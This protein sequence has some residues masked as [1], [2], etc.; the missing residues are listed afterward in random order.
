[1]SK[2]C[3]FC[4]SSGER[5]GCQK[6]SCMAWDEVRGRCLLIPNAQEQAHFNATI[7]R[8]IAAIRGLA[9]RL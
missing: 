8:L 9:G 1:M 5:E 2:I 6:K 3:P 7:D 4:I